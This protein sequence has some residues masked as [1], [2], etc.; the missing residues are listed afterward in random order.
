MNMH[1]TTSG[2]LSLMGIAF[3]ILF[4]S[5]IAPAYHQSSMASVPSAIIGL[6]SKAAKQYAFTF[7]ELYPLEEDRKLISKSRTKVIGTIEDVNFLGGIMQIASDKGETLTVQFYPLEVSTAVHTKLRL[8]LKP[9]NRIKSVCAVA[10]AST[11][12]LVSAMVMTS[13]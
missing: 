8:A 11:L 5:N 13:N 2:K 6:Q 3:T 4:S 9:G 10:G 12:D 1:L 7:E